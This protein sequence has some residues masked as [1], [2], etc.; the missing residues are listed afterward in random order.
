MN[1][2]DAELRADAGA[3]IV[4][5]GA[6]SIPIG[7]APAA[8]GAVRLG[9]R[10]QDI[11]LVVV[12]EPSD[13]AGRIDVIEPLGPSLLCHVLVDGAPPLRLRVTTSP[14]AELAEG[15]AVHL[16]LR[17]DRLHLFAAAGDQRRL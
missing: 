14:D 13:A 12:G 15:D 16:H 10:P 8:T 17:R 2:V 5:A 11:A 4:R 6:L 7:P 3:T 9:V 1:L